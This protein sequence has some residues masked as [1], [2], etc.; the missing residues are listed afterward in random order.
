VAGP[1]W[2]DHGFIARKE[3][4]R[5]AAQPI[6]L[7]REDGGARAAWRRGGRR[8]RRGSRDKMGE[9]GA[10]EAGTTV[11]LATRD[12]QLQELA[13]VTTWSAGWRISTRARAAAVRQARRR[14]D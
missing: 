10:F 6:R 13:P 9:N 7:A 12:A 14:Q 3:A 1:V 5:V 4:E 2:P 8:R 11:T